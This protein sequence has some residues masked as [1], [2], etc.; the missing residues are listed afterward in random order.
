[1]LRFLKNLKSTQQNRCIRVV[2]VCTANCCRSPLAEILFEK[3]LA[4]ELGTIKSIFQKN[5]LVESAAT[6]YSGYPISGRSAGL[7]IDEENIE[8]ERCSRHRGRQLSEIEEPDLIL[9]MTDEHKE[10]ILQMQPLWDN[11]TF[12]LDEF[13][14]RDKQLI[15]IDIEDPMGGT[16]AEYKRMKNHIKKN[17]IMLLNEFKAAGLLD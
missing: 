16:D 8:P 9:A 13:V 2:F 5:I 6:H 10:D 15:A 3:L 7:L 12:T 11:L 17:L 4:D 14:K 1:M